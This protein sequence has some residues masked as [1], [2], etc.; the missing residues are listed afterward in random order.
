MRLGMPIIK[1]LQQHKIL[2]DTYVWLWAMT[3][4]P[5]LSI[6]FSQAFEKILKT[7][8]ILI[9]PMSVWEIGMLVEKGRIEIEMDVMDWISQSL[10]VSDMQLCPISPRI[11]IQSTRL[12]G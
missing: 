11:A 2:L 10:D 4:D 6:D 1:S 9:S 3:A 8:G 12:P 5:I 7:Q